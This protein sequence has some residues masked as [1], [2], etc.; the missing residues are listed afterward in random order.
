MAAK[1]SNQKS[2]GPMKRK[3]KYETAREAIEKQLMEKD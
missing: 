3:P 2:S 1:N